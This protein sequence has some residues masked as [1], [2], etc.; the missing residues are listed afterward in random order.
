[1]EAMTHIEA[2][3]RCVREYGSVS[4]RGGC[5]MGGRG[6]TILF[7]VAVSFL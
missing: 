2:T 3:G 7:Q 6:Q 5:K 1:V 4:G